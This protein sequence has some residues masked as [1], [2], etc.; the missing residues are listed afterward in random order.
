M[1]SEIVCDFTEI[2]L[3]FGQIPLLHQ[4]TSFGWVV[5]VFD[6]LR[7]NIEFGLGREVLGGS[8]F[9]KGADQQAETFRSVPIGAAQIESQGT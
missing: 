6:R 5:L 1:Q 8:G 3:E 7:H 9:I 2:E 4:H